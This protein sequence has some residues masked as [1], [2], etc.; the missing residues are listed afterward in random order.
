[1]RNGLRLVDSGRELEPLKVGAGLG[2]SCG[3]GCLNENCDVFVVN[4]YCKSLG[5]WRKHGV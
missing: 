1:M 3:V 2:F 4:Y 5:V